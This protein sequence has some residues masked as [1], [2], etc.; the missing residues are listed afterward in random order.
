MV[1]N[2]I[3]YAGLRC[4]KRTVENIADK[5][6]ISEWAKE[7]YE[8]IGGCYISDVG[9]TDHE[10]PD[11]TPVRV[12]NPQKEATRCE[13][14]YILNNLESACQLYASDLAVQYGFDKEMPIIDGSTSTYPFTRAVYGELFCNG[15]AHPMYPEKHSKSHASYQRLINR[16]VDMIFASVYPASDI[17]EMAKEK[18]VE[19]ELIPIA[20]DAMIFFTNKDNE[21]TGLTKEQISN[22]YVNDAYDNWSEVGGSDALM[23][24]YCR[25]NDSGSHAQME[26]HFLN[27]KEINKE[28]QR[29][30]SETMS[31]ILTDV[32]AAKTD[33]PKGYGLGYSIYYYYH[34]MNMFYDVHEQLKLLAID[35]VMPTDETI[36]DGTY[37]LSNNTYIALLKD[38]PK[39]APARKMAEFM[40]TDEGQV[41][42]ELAGFGKLK[43]TVEIS[44]DMLF[45]DKLNAQMPQDENYMFSP[46]SIK[47]ALA[48]AA[49]GASGETQEQILKAM[50]IKSLDEFNSV[51][52][53]LIDR[54]SQTDILSLKIVNSIWMNKD[55]TSQNFSDRYKKIATEYYEAEVKSVDNTNAV[56]EINGWVDDKTNGKIP[57]I[58]ESADDF[59]AMLI[60]A[61]YFK[62][63][64]QNEFSEGATAPARFNNADGTMITTDFMNK[65]SWIPYAETKSVK[66]IELPYKNRLDKFNENGEYTDTERYDD[67]D[68]GMY[69]IMA[70]G[71]I[72]V[73]QELTAAINDN[74]FES[75]YIK[76]A[77]PKFRIEYSTSLNDMLKNMGIADAFD[78]EK[79][80][81]YNMFDEGNM[82]FTNTIHKTFINVDEK[83]TEAAAVTALA[84]AGSAL[85]PEPMELKFNKPFYFVIRD[86]TS[87]ETLFMGRYAYAY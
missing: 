10:N 12:L 22:I 75:K 39:D 3:G 77:M 31:D 82:W 58:I 50:G 55:K 30:T 62:G 6:T 28:V 86:N 76:L 74:A 11:D 5:D 23:Y 38:T 53:N 24:P 37:P 60:N 59:W 18:G 85:P 84:M 27:G 57:T 20:Y 43:R 19:I 34:N 7:A 41:C 1:T 87:G 26:K 9:Y 21:V 61:I 14:A 71:D 70:D 49:N 51:A 29:E 79:A 40:L 45:T 80:D 17:L 25:N 67:L 42:V 72:N 35:G 69:I 68:V 33:D 78:S 73:E 81:F 48:L 32:M 8:L 83:G 13:V 16:E 63:A 36:A 52:C 65:T 2:A 54:Y 56:D 15:N 66:M 4:A 46:M 47:M 64:W 44:E